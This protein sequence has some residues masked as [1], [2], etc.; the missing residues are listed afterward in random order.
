MQSIPIILLSGSTLLLSYLLFVNPRDVNKKGNFWLALFFLNIFLLTVPEILY[1]LNFDNNTIISEFVFTIPVFTIM[2]CFYL[3]VCYFIN[4]DFNDLK[5]QLY[6]FVFLFVFL[7]FY[8]LS[9]TVLCDFFESINSLFSYI[10]S[11]FFYLMQLLLF[12]S[13]ALIK[14]HKYQKNIELVNSDTRKN[15]LKWLE[16]TTFLVLFMVV[17][18][19]ITDLYNSIIVRNISNLIYFFCFYII[20]YFSMKQSELYPFEKENKK[21]IIDIV[22]DFDEKKIPQKKLIED[23]NLAVLKKNLEQIMD[24][25]KP[26]LDSE[27]NLI[28]LAQMMNI[29]AHQLSYLINTAFGLNF[30]NF[31][32]KYRVENVK[33]NLSSYNLKHLTITGIGFES[34]FNSKSAFNIA[35]KK[36]TGMTP[37]DFIK[38]TI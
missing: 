4:P 5:Q 3:A 33:T 25:E 23:K 13:L 7:F 24:T 9:N 32:N 22:T 36:H 20:S 6:S 35:F 2:P 16:Y 14:I 30:Y 12:S 27:L 11:I 15:N 34:G 29:N 10:V 1:F 8:V 18:L 19:V 38:K 31:I 17:M 26:F 28:K 37:K 21:Q